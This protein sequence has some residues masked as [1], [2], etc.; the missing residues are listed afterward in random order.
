MKLK[1]DD[2]NN[3]NNKILPKEVSTI[4]NNQG[5]IVWANEE[6]INSL[7]IPQGEFIN[8]KTST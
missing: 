4:K 7:I 1:G 3:S 5:E 8:K 6:Y 2:Y